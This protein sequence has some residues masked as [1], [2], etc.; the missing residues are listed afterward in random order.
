MNRRGI[1]TPEDVWESGIQLRG[2]IIAA[3]NKGNLPAGFKSVDRL[4]TVDGVDRVVSTKSLDASLPTYDGKPKAIESRLNG[5]LNDLDSF[6]KGTHTSK[7][8]NV[9]E[10]KAT[11]YEEK[12][13][14]V[15]LR[16]GTMSDADW[17]AVSRVRD[18]ATAKGITMEVH[19][20][21]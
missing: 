9:V 12:V 8:G 6:D 5:Y 21:P 18:R 17:A 7:S 4:E 15:F 10:V 2:L 14:E 11:D 20:Y 16:P 3:L 19:E 1:V 13:L